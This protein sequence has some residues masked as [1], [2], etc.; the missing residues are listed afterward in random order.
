M[1][2]DKHSCVHLFTKEGALV[3]SIGHGVLSGF[4]GG[5]AFDRNGN[6]W[7]TDYFNN[8]AVML[9]QDGKLLL[10]I[11]NFNH[12]S[13]VSVCPDGLIYICDTG[14]LRVIV[15]DEDGECLFTF[16]STQIG[17]VH[18]DGPHDIAFGSDG[19]VYVTDTGNNNII[20]ALTKRGTFKKAFKPIYDQTFI[21]ATNDN[22][23]LISSFPSGHIMVYTTEGELVHEFRQLG[24]PKGIFV[25]HSGVVGVV[26]WLNCHVKV[27]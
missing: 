8:K 11:H 5:V 4:L 23:L 15:L 19:L 7:V 17:P 21:A 3:R 14:N 24:G 12:P 26:S 10:S 20:Y 25:D 16:S 1:T 22:H 9:S 6:V 18:F 13:G 27:L 2:D